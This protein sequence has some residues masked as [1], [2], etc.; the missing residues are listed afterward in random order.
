MTLKTCKPQGELKR[1]LHGDA[2]YQGQMMRQ[3]IEGERELLPV[4]MMRSLFLPTPFSLR[5]SICQ[6]SFH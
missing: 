4:K 1:A 6:F 2:E 5:I 3:E